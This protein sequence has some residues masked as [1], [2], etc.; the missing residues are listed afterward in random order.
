MTPQIHRIATFVACILPAALAFIIYLPVLD[1]GFVWDDK[2]FLYD[3]PEFRDP[4][5]WWDAITRPFFVSQNYFRPLA[6]ATFVADYQ[7]NGLDPSVYH[8]TNLILHALNTLLITVLAWHLAK[9]RLPRTTALLAGSIAGLLYG[10][11]P[12]LIEAVSWVSVRFDLLLASFLL[13]AITADTFIKNRYLKALLVGLF[14]LGAA[15]SKEM[16]APFPLVLLCLHAALAASNPSREP[17]IIKA[18]LRDHWRTYVS[19]I[20]AGLVYLWLRHAALGYILTEQQTT[21]LGPL[22]QHVLVIGKAFLL[23]AQLS[24][25]PYTTISPLHPLELPID[26]SALSEWLGMAAFFTSLMTTGWLIRKQHAAGWLFLAVILSYLPVLWILPLNTQMNIGHERFMVFPLA[27]TIL[28]LVSAL[29]H[30]NP[31]PLHLK[32]AC[33]T[34]TILLATFV[35]VLNIINIRVT[36]PLWK[37]NPS[38]WAWATYRAPTARVALVNLLAAYVEREQFDKAEQLGWELMKHNPMDPLPMLTLSHALLNQQ[39]Y[40]EALTVLKQALEVLPEEDGEVAPLIHSNMGVALSALQRCD[41]A[42][43]EFETAIRLDPT[44]AGAH[45]NLGNLLLSIGD[46]KGATKHLDTAFRFFPPDLATAKRHATETYR[47]A[48]EAGQVTRHCTESTVSEPPT[49]PEDRSHL[50]SENTRTGRKPARPDT[51]LMGTPKNQDAITA[52]QR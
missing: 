18:V 2:M 7:L 36:V 4:A 23:Y 31:C 29:P 51:E 28:L 12:A 27:L 25:W 49:Q 50:G 33:T 16:A 41:E 10:L 8:L 39:S 26:T 20:T 40:K 30:R 21:D 38:L 48:L 5:L 9:A 17:S 14:Y 13:G 43:R 52:S 1:N 45:Y 44:N 42:R 22:L 6:L 24:I 15:L 34:G 3:S 11:H 35:I 47:K 19:L 46:H 32:R 37:D